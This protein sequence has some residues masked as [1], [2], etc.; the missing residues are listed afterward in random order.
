MRFVEGVRIPGA[1][2][3]VVNTV[4]TIMTRRFGKAVREGTPGPCGEGMEAEL[5]AASLAS[6]RPLKFERRA[7]PSNAGLISQDDELNDF[8]FVGREI[9]SQDERVR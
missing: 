7:G 5:I 3:G 4:V 2:L 8:V 1:A 6:V 9:E